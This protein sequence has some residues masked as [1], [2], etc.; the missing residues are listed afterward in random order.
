MD[1]KTEF[2]RWS[3]LVNNQKIFLEAIEFTPSEAS[4][5]TNLLSL[6]GGMANFKA[7]PNEIGDPPFTIEFSP[8]GEHKLFR[9]EVIDPIKFKFNEVDDLIQAVNACMAIAVDMQ[10]VS[11]KAIPQHRGPQA[12]DVF[13]GRG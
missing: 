7:L 1:R 9:E 4:K 12:G 13:E 3:S 8:D 5:I 6:A 2:G 11:P 10:K